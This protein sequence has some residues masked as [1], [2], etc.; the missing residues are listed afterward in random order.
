MPFIKLCIKICVQMKLS[1]FLWFL[2]FGRIN[3][4]ADAASCEA[5]EIAGKKNHFRGQARTIFMSFI[6]N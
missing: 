3:I 1:K 6:D 2:S 5:Y 4:A